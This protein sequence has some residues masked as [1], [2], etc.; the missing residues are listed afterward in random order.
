[1]TTRQNLIALT[2]VGQVAV[3]RMQ[4]EA[5]HNALNHESIEQFHASLD[6]IE[7]RDDIRCV[8]VTGEG[9]KTFSAGYDLRGLAEI[10][11]ESLRDNPLPPLIDRIF[12]F[13]LPTIGAINGGAYGAGFHLMLACDL[14]V[15]Q[16]GSKFFVPA[17]QLGLVY[18]PSALVLMARELGPS[19]AKRLMLAG[20]RF[21]VDDLQAAGFFA[22][23]EEPERVFDQAMQL[24]ERVATGAPISIQGMKK[25]INGFGA[26]PETEVRALEEKCLVSADLKEG[27]RASLAKDRPTFRGR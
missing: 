10:E 8:I 12:E 13:P 1:M 24:A 5:C 25:I 4:R 27:I 21:G 15:G 7:E 3:I 11:P 20:E 19:F 9:S 26:L 22:S 17:A 23:I 16:I 14:R 2:F 6:H 18:N